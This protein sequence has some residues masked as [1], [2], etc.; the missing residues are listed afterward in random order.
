MTLE[1]E[2]DYDK[3]SE[4]DEIMIEGFASAIKSGDSVTLTVK[5]SGE[6]IALKLTLTERQRSILLAGGMLNYTK[7]NN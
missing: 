2:A 6:K 5:N 7:E 4:A 3:I 1:N